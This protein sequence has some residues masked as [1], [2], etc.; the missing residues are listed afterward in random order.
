MC[1]ILVLFSSHIF[2]WYIV[3]AISTSVYLIRRK[4]RAQG[5]FKAQGLVFHAK[6]MTQEDEL[7][8]LTRLERPLRSR[9][10]KDILII[11]RYL[12]NTNRFFYSLPAKIQNQILRVGTVRYVTEDERM[13]KK[14]DRSGSFYIILKGTFNVSSPDRNE[15]GKFEVVMS[16]SMRG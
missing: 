10:S 5:H 12:R 3:V 9:E 14:G 16:E 8:V 7:D 11:A 13:F 6:L 1:Y 15:D 2:Y 4:A